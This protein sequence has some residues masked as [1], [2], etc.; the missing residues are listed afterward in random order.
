MYALYIICIL[1]SSPKNA[2]KRHRLSKTP[3]PQPS[4]LT[5]GRTPA[6]RFQSF[7]RL[8]PLPRLRHWLK[9]A[10]RPDC[11]RGFYNRA[12]S[13]LVT[14]WY[15]VWQRLGQDHTLE[16]VVADARNGGADRLRG[17]KRLSRQLKSDATASYSDAR[18]RLPLGVLEE[19]LRHF[20]QAL[21]KAL[22]TPR[23]HGSKVALIDGSTL[24]LRSLG[25]IPKSFPPHRVGN[26]QRHPYWCLARVVG[27]FCAE[28]GAIL[29]SAMD[30]T[31]H[32]EQKLAARLF[33][34]SW[35]EW[36]VLGDRNFGVYFVASLIRAAQ[37]HAL[38]RL[39]RC[40]ALSLARRAGLALEP[41]LDAVID[42]TPT[43]HD[44][45]AQGVARQAVPG[46]LMAVVVQPP[47]G[48]RPVTLYLLST[49]TDSSISSQEWARLYGR[50]WS[51]E[52]CFRHLKTQM[53]LELLN[54][55]S[56]QIARKDWLAGLLAYN[57]IRYTMGTAAAVHSV[58][59]Q[60][61]SFAHARKLLLAWLLRHGDK[62]LSLGSW[63]T[64]LQRIAK[65][66]LPKRK[67]KRPSEPRA[68]RRFT[69]DVSILI[70]SRA[71][72]RLKLANAFPKS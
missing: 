64:L 67:K 68:I 36:L 23:F 19:A 10:Q 47:N 51:V 69:R 5:L 29:G 28:T 2:L 13:P 61:L 63:T 27:L 39:T 49:L 52:L 72:A 16:A 31:Q 45:S 8:V 37:G 25:D 32:S 42:W 33:Q 3:S 50:R 17:A 22:Q 14:L 4:L 11:P 1:I 20:A 43:R 35:P 44:Q 54:C 15:L 46:R 40:R 65:A 6:Q 9:E 24:R 48:T 56:A 30:S 26:G 58:P 70:G 12:F 66:R 60:L 71:A 18:Q 59:V 21:Q 57:L 62:R 41:G 53:G 38:L 55:R 7:R 34:R